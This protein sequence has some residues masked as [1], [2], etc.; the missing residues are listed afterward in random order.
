MENNNSRENKKGSEGIV[1]P[2]EQCYAASLSL[3]HVLS[4]QFLILQSLTG[5]KL[6]EVF[7]FTQEMVLILLLLLLL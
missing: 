6:P 2:K 5:C 1:G 7:F 4:Q 3:D